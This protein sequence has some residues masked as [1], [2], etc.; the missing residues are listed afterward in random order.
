MSAMGTERKPNSE[1]LCQNCSTK[2]LR[3]NLALG[4]LAGRSGCQ[5]LS[6]PRPAS[7][8]H[9]EKTTIDFGLFRPL[10]YFLNV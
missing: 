8:S 9:P 7:L 1:G 6:V 3:Q 10:S 5:G 4:R 2:C